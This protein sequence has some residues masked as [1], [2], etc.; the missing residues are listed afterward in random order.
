MVLEEYRKSADQ[1][2]GPFARYFRN[3]D[4]STLTVMSFL[5]AVLA[6]IFF[7][8]TNFRDWFLLIAP[9]F[10]FLNGFFD[11][12]D[13]R[14]ARI[15]K[16]ASPRGDFLD[17][18]LDRYAD[19]FIIGGIA[20]SPYCPPVIGLLAL[21]GVIFASYMGTQAQAVGC[22]RDYKGLLGRADRLVILIFAPII[23]Y[24]L[25]WP[26][27]NLGFYKVTLVIDKYVIPMEFTF[28]A[29]VMLI[30]AIIGHVT[31]IQRAINTWRELKE[32]DKTHGKRS[33]ARSDAQE[34]K[35]APVRGIKDAQDAKGQE[36]A[37]IDTG[38]R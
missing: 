15:S 30:F 4:P 12:L 36:N 37:T 11:V 13:G 7:V 21:I 38:K 22:G 27:L 24:P 16:K 29:V 19:V 34:G 9:I 23:Q 33:A 31:A 10:V 35:T 18:V 28:L 26:G 8:L 25:M 14:V 32:R 2:V 17:H 5:C 1:Y 6:G 20:L 3:A